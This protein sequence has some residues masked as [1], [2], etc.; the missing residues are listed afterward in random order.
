MQLPEK[1][2]GEAQGAVISVDVLQVPQVEVQK[3]TPEGV[4]L[5]SF[6]ATGYAIL[7]VGVSAID[8]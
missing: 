2:A 5:L 7:Q 8:T 1:G 6:F 4:Y 3:S